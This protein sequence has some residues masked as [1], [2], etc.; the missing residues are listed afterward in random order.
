MAR[1]R[2]RQSCS[3]KR[4]FAIAL[5]TTVKTLVSCA[6][7]CVTGSQIASLV[8]CYATCLSLPSVLSRILKRAL[9]TNKQG[10]RML[11]T[12]ELT[13][14]RIALPG[15]PVLPVALAPC[16]INLDWVTSYIQSICCRHTALRPRQIST[17]QELLGIR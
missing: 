10:K 4:A 14:A 13:A 16:L 9:S 1:I 17:P 5:G 15:K 12:T 2:K 3:C 7:L 11:T 8:C 6:M